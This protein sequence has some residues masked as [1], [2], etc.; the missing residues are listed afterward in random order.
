MD[1]IPRVDGVDTGGDDGGVDDRSPG[2][3]GAWHRLQ[4]LSAL[5]IAVAAI[6]LAAWEGLENRRHNRLTVRPRLA[7]EV[8]TGRTAAAEHASIAIENTGLGPAVL[9]RFDVYL[10]GA[11]VSGDG[12]GWQA[13]IAA[14]AEEGLS[15]NA[16]GYGEGYFVPAGTRLVLFEARRPV[17]PDGA[18]RG[19]GDLLTRVAVDLCYCSVYGTDCD[20]VVLTT[21]RFD[22]P[23]CPT[24]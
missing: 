12:G 20:Q 15:L 4:S 19:I 24:D 16:Q 3:S 6:V 18:A 23:A 22:V 14:V 2:R 17:P 21:S 9:H 7:G 10:D 13:V 1:E 5:V 8:N 11:R